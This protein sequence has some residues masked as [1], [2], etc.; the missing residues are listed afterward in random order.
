ML[1]RCSKSRLRR[2]HRSPPDR[3]LLEG[4]TQAGYHCCNREGRGGRCRKGE[5]V[6]K[7]PSK[8]R[9][10]A[11]KS[12]KPATPPKDASESQVKTGPIIDAIPA[13]V[14]RKPDV[15]PVTEPSAEAPA[16]AADPA[17]EP[18]KSATPPPAPKPAAAPKP[19]A[20]PLVLGGLTAGVIGFAVATLTAHRPMMA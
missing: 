4:W 12:K 16:V 17:P 15:T 3:R 6:A 9:K 11:S 7:Q 18:P 1:R 20:L 5:I 8:G 14:H 13:E 2:F 10:P 19:S